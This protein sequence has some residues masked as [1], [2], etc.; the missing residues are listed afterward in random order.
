MACNEV[1]HG[2]TYHSKQDRALELFKMDTYL[3]WSS[4]LMTCQKGCSQKLGTY[5]PVMFTTDSF[6]SLSTPVSAS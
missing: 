3:D 4:F 6:L 1:L 5:L 2:F